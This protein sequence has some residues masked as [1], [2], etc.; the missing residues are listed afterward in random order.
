MIKVLVVDD[1]ALVRKILSEELAKY[2]DLEVVGSAVDPFAARDKI[3]RLKP[4]VITLDLEMP[5]MDGLTFL[6]K[7]MTYYPIPTVVVSSLAPENSE[8][9]LKA[10]GLGAVEVLCKPGSAFSTP[11]IAEQ[12]VRAVRSAARVKVKKPDLQPK[13][14]AAPAPLAGM[15]SRTT[16]KVLGIGA[17]TGGTQALE[18]LLRSLPSQTPGIAIVQ[19]MPPFFTSTFAQ[20]LDSICDIE[21][22][23]AKDE[24]FLAPGLAL[25]APGGRHLQVQRSGAYYQV[26]VK[27]GPPVHH[28]KPSVDVLFNSLAGAAG[29][30]AVGVLLTGMGSDGAA[31]LKAMRDKG[32]YTIAQDEKS[33]VVW[34]MPGE[35]VKMGAACEVSGLMEMHS[36]IMRAVI[37]ETPSQAQGVR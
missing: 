11:D 16:Q 35:A 14:D 24:D 3:A 29:P 13:P 18:I 36:S 17:S 30:N 8:N 12:L 7:L 2:G 1:S 20:R 28:Q 22:R 31:G 15:L 23:E 10:L 6:S 26:R 37:R 33:S 25:I 27:E 5:R 21:V 4:D 34:G 32:A 9:A 19:H